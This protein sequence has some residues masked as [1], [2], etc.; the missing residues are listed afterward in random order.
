MKKQNHL[1]D[2]TVEELRR[3]KEFIEECLR[4]EEELYNF[5]FNKSSVHIGGMKSR[6]M[7]E[8]HEE[9]C[10]EYNERIKKIDEILRT[11]RAEE[12]R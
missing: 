6:A 2:M 5:T 9:K 7:Q 10:R 11:R 3:E 1:E 8:R 4:D 12:K